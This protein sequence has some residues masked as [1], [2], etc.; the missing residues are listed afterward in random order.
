MEIQISPKGIINKC[1]VPYLFA[2]QKTRIVFGGSSSGKSVWL[3]QEYALGVLEGRNTLVARKVAK[4]TLE[5]VV[6]TKLTKFTL[7]SYYLSPLI[8]YSVF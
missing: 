3:S 2:P 8:A 4:T 6:G 7:L 5:A 1:Y